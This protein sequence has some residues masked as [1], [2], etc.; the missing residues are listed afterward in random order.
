VLDR[1]VTCPG[2][3]Y[4]SLVPMPAACPEWKPCAAIRQN[5]RGRLASRGLTSLK[6]ASVQWLLLV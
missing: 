3:A 2:L 1:N 6:R 4:G 5:T